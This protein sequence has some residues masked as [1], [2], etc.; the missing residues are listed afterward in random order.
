MS[1]SVELNAVD[2]N[3]TNTRPKLSCGRCLGNHLPTDRLCPARVSRCN[4]CNKLGHYAR[5]CRGGGKPLPQQPKQFSNQKRQAQDQSRGDYREQKPKFVREIDDVTN[6]AEIRELFHLGAKRTT[7]VSVGGVDLIFIIDTGADEDVLSVGDW[8]TLKKTGFE[9]FTIRKGS[10]KIF[11]AYGSRK[12]L[13]V[14]GEVD[15]MIRI[16]DQE[17]RT[18]F[19]VIQDGK[20][21]LLSGRSAEQL[22]VV[23]FLRSVSD[24]TFPSIKGEKAKL[25]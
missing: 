14:L 3:T 2:Q 20:H 11:Q 15:A 10:K 18:T 1:S 13:K 16:G 12:P 9:A 17:C 23:K 5:C 22:G 7:K 6:E 25:I 21:S 8:T 19:Y 24:E 4:R